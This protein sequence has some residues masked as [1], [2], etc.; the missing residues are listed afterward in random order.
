M[1][2]RQIHKMQKSYLREL[3]TI[4]HQELHPALKAFTTSPIENFYIEA[5]ESPFSLRRHKLFSCPQNSTDNCIMVKPDW[6]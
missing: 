2:F 4:H 5:N 6:K 1:P 3:E